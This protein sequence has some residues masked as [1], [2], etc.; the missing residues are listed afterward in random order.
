MQI[1]FW[2]FCWI[3]DLSKNDRATHREYA[4]VI[5]KNGVECMITVYVFWATLRKT[6]GTVLAHLRPLLLLRECSY[7]NHRHGCKQ[8]FGFRFL[9]FIIG[10]APTRSLHKQPLIQKT[11][12]GCRTLITND[13]SMIFF[14]DDCFIICGENL[15]WKRKNLTSSFAQSKEKPSHVN[16]ISLVKQIYEKIM[17]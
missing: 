6:V 7:V 3:Y 2:I 9:N 5:S 15:C 17:Q 1:W 8:L 13:N 4:L 14:M 16:K 11:I 12:Q 10:D